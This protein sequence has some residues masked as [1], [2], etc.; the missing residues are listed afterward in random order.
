[1]AR[2]R[3]SLALPVAAALGATMLLAA[4]AH[5]A[6]PGAVLATVM[7]VPLALLALAGAWAR[8]LELRLDPYEAR[9]A[10]WLWPPCVVLIG[11]LLVAYRWG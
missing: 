6:T 2:R 8:W 10:G 1:M 3:G 4:E 11:F 5:A 7:R 9:W